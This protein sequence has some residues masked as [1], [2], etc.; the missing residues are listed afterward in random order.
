M[1]IMAYCLGRFD[2]T[3]Y[4]LCD[5]D[6]VRYVRIGDPVA[7]AHLVM[8][9]AD[10]LKRAMN[11]HKIALSLYFH[12]MSGRFTPTN[13]GLLFIGITM[14][15]SSGRSDLFYRIRTITYDI[16]E[17]FPQTEIDLINRTKENTNV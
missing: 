17:N 14:S 10:T 12:L 2:N 3:R 7:A 11:N 13:I 5:D 1:P 9:D 16:A 15:P 8:A 6:A 4:W